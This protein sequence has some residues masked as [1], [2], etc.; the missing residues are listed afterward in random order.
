MGIG[1]QFEFEKTGGI[2]SE[3]RESIETPCYV[4]SGER[5]MDKV[6]RESR[7]VDR[8]VLKPTSGDD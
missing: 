5:H 3:H 8:I 4:Q 1:E 7:N 2:D 6:L